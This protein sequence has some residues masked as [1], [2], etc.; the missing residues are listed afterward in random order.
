MLADE[1]ITIVDIIYSFIN[2][3]KFVTGKV[4]IIATL[5]ENSISV[6]IESFNI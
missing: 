3:N 2:S 5:G 6:W 1:F 4:N